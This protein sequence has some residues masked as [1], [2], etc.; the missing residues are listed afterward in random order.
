MN[1][2]GFDPFEPQ[3][4]SLPD[5]QMRDNGKIMSQLGFNISQNLEICQNKNIEKSFNTD[6][7]YFTKYE[8]KTHF[9][10]SH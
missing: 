4:E 6:N 5:Q 1:D 10:L 8:L 3:W 9:K 2:S 7:I